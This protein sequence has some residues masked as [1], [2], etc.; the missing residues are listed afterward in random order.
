M[1]QRSTKALLSVLVVVLMAA[2]VAPPMLVE[3]SPDATIPPAADPAEPSLPAAVEY[4]LGEATIVQERFAEGDRFRNMPV[5]L[6]GVIAAPSE[7]EGPFPLVVIIHGTHPG[8]PEDEMGVDR[9]PC[10][11]EVERRNYSGFAY[12]ASALAGQGYIVLVPNTN[13]EHT[14]GF[15]EPTAGERLTQ[16]LD[17]HMQAVG[18]AAAGGANDFGVELAGRADLSRLALFGHSRGGEAALALANLPAVQEASQGYGPVAGVLQI[19]AAATAVDPWN[20]SAVPLATILSACDA[21]V[22]AQ[23]GQFFFEGIRLA[24]QD[25]WATSA[26]LERANHNGFNTFLGRDPFGLSGRPDCEPLLDPEAQRAWLVDYAGDFLTTLRLA[27]EDAAAIDAAKAR[28]GLD[29]T[30]PAPAELYGQPA[31]VA[32]LAPAADRQTVLIPAEAEELAANRL[33]G[34]VA[35]EGVTPHFCPKGFYSAWSAP[36]SEP[37]R[38]NYVT[39]PGQPAHAV[40]SWEQPGTALRFAL[41]EGS[42]DL[43]GYTTLSLRAAVDPASPLNAAGSP[44]AFSVQLTDR[45]GQRAVAQTRPDEPALAFPPGEM[46]EV[47]ATETGFFTGRVPLT[48]IRLALSDFAGVDLAD[49]AEIALVFDQTPSG[50][51]FLA[52]LEWVRPLAP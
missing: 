33:G 29:V 9:W 36:G 27:A 5:R 22:V 16:L 30:T 49:I 4:N 13:A 6:N 35:A 37:C 21:D 42:G 14:F 10:S 50:A 3:P 28:M 17:L 40:V 44:Q 18:E 47:T 39:V 15:G 48:T 25:T 52:D 20:G 31:R 24:G 26:W 38:R 12:L 51:L 34:A 19:A 11:P 45:A 8:C 2:C 41:P 43:S 7:G 46:Q 1:V 32:F 23:D